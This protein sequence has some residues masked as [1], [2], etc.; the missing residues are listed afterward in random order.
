MHKKRVVGVLVLLLA[1]VVLLSGCAKGGK[2]DHIGDDNLKHIDLVLDY[3]PNTNH[4]GIYV[5]IEKGYFK[6]AGFEVSVIQPPEDG[7]DGL[8]ASGKA[9]YGVAYQDMMANYL[10]SSNPLPVSAIATILQH[11]TSG[12]MSASDKEILRPRDLENK[13]YATW[14][15][16]TEQA[17][18]KNVVECDKGDWNKVELV[19]CNTTDEVASLKA[20]EFD[21][22][23]VYEGWAVQNAKI[24]DF[25]YNYFAFKDINPV[26][27]YYTPVIIVNNDYLE[28]N[29]QESASFIEALG[30]GY[31][32]A[33]ENPHEAAD[34]LCKQ[35]PELDH[36]L[37]E[38]SQEY[39]SSQYLDTDGNFGKIDKDR[40]NRFYKW[41]N[42]N[43]LVEKD[44]PLNAG[45]ASEE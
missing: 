33:A 38:L 7:A 21:S 22:V 41:M 18:V 8:V 14:N 40:W 34:I 25:D 30:K 45:L 19:P 26:F 15:M 3:T 43:K 13:S 11:N 20:G 5:A 16:Q 23:W 9:Q 4:T 17:I 2:E 44:I 6:D 24:Q 28:N 10:G 39:L 37:V 29:R 32:F 12:I 31:K 35:V 36:K 27:D 42:D 1:T